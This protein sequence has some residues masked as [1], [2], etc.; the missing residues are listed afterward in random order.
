M[1][2]GTARRLGA[3]GGAE[4]KEF[5]SGEIATPLGSGY[6]VTVLKITCLFLA[7][8]ITT[9]LGYLGARPPKPTTGYETQLWPGIESLVNPPCP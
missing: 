1:Y 3:A 5:V 2:C 8:K 7:I 4:P 9:G 6:A